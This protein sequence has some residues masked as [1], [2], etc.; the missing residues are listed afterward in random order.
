ME[1]DKYVAPKFS[2]AMKDLADMLVNDHSLGPS[3]TSMNF[4]GSSIKN[5]TDGQTS[6]LSQ[7]SAHDNSTEVHL[8]NVMEYSPPDGEV[9]FPINS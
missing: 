1:R 2:E 9:L 7:T 5:K 4:R 6:I 8:Q 3:D